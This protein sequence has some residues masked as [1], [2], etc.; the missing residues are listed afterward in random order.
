MPEAE[1]STMSLLENAKSH[2]KDLVAFDTTSRYTNRPL[3]DHMAAFLR[4]YGIEP[5]ILLDETG[6][7]ANLI[8]RIGPADVPGVVLSGHTDVVPA[9][10]KGWTSPPFDLTERDGKLYGRGSCDMKGFAAC[11]MAMVP[12]LVAAIEAALRR[13][14]AALRGT[15]GDG[16]SG[17][18][19]RPRLQELMLAEGLSDVLA[20]AA[21][22]GSLSIFGFNA[23]R[24]LGFPA[25]QASLT[26]TAI[27]V[28]GPE[29]D[30]NVA[31]PGQST[32]LSVPGFGVVLNALATSGDANVLSIFAAAACG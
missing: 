16:S 19:L 31:L 7:K 25:D 12:Q 6:E 2:L 32:G 15:R 9:L 11:V 1:K 10:E 18:L 26:G 20:S 24:S 22:E 23:G 4:E 17:S 5:V 28:R 21:G 30:T 27:G 13:S 8:A 3:I 14:M 29:I